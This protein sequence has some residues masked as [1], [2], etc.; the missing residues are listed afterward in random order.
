M[1]RRLGNGY[2]QH[3]ILELDLDRGRIDAVGQFKP[4]LKSSL[5]LLHPMVLDPLHL[6]VLLGVILTLSTDG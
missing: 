3:S 6:F 2:F 5:A 1:S 4:A